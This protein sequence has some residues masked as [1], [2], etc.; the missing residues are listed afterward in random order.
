MLYRDEATA[1]GQPSALNTD[2]IHEIAHRPHGIIPLPADIA[3]EV[4]DKLQRTLPE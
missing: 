4:D 3:Q 1:G 2:L